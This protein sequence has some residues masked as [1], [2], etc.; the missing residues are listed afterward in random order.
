[1]RRNNN[2]PAAASPGSLKEAEA[3]LEAHPELAFVDLLIPDIQGL[4][5]GK[6]I[7]ADLLPKVFRQGLRLPGS[8]FALDITGENVEGTGL[9]FAEGEKDRICRPVPNSLKPVPWAPRQTAQA[10]ITMFEEDGTPFFADPRH[11]LEG[12][13]ARYAARGL[14][15]VIAVEL[16]FYLFDRVR[17]EKGRPRF[18][19]SPVTGRRPSLTQCY[20]MDDIYHFEPVLQEIADACAAQD[21]PAH[22]ALSEY[23]PAQFEIN[24]RHVPDAVLAADHGVL[25]KRVVK[26]VALKH[27]LDASFMAKPLADSTSS[28][29]HVHFSLLDATGR[30]VFDDGSPAGSETMR[31]ALGGIIATLPE[32]FALLAPNANS[33]R[34]YGLG[35]YAPLSPAWGI[36]NR[37]T[38]LR[39]PPEGEG[40]RRIEHRFAGADAHPHLVVAAAL[41]GA[42]HGIEK[43]LEPGPPVEGN[44]YVQCP[45]T[46]PI[47][48]DAALAAFE[49]ARTLPAYLGAEF[50]RVYAQVRRQERDRFQKAVTPLEYEWYLLNV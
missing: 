29:A 5:R 13:V 15:P 33:F 26:N 10:L 23:A 35:S 3:F 43:R 41:A 11:V 19:V 32:A 12:I 17:D 18:P 21:I 2:G 49:A 6:R 28:G 50:C 24:L 36:N 14:T 16:E 39:I 37:T 47:T 31:H 42:L 1:M 46:L 4:I 27:G 22:T 38:G 25:L 7:N 8:V 34:R 40:Q 20:G 44:A 30:N 9:I 48:W 45:P